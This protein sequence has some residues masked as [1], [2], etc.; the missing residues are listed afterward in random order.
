MAA[1][2]FD[3]HSLLKLFQREKGYKKVV[4][5]LEN[6]ETRKKA[7]FMSVVNF[8]EIIYIT[9]K[10]FGDEAKIKIIASV[11][12]MGF[13]VVSA[14]DDLVY[15]AA[16]IKGTYPMSFGDCFAM[17]TALEKRAILVIGDPE[18]HAVEKLIKIHWCS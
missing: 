8:A 14:D 1:Y 18:F 6:L 5:L 17:A 16:E 3:S 15:A 7:K 12:E 9:K 10:R 4:G 13:E 2:V 11:H